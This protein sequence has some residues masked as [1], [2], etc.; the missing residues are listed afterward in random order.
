MIPIG[1]EGYVHVRGGAAAL[2]SSQQWN[3]RC[4]KNESQL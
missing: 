1:M 3:A 4:M 2:E